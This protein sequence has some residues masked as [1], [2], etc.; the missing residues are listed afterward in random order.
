M[1]ELSSYLYANEYSSSAI[2]LA[3]AACAAVNYLVFDGTKQGLGLALLCAVAAPASELVLMANF[4]LWHYPHGELYTAI[5]GG[6]PK[7]VPFCYF[8]YVPAVSN[9]ARYLWKTM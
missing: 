7:W 4:E 5:A 1:L 8:F 9:L 6:I 2:C 3:L